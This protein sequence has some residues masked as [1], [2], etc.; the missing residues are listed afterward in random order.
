MRRLFGLGTKQRTFEFKCESCNEIHRG[1]PSFAIPQPTYVHDVPPDER[2][3]RLE[4]SEDLCVIQPRNDSEQ[5]TIF[6]I[7]VLLEI[8]IHGAEE[9]FSWG[10]WV[11]QSE[12]S[13]ARY[14]E[15]FDQDQSGD[16]SFGWLPMTIGHYR[17]TEPGQDIEHLACDVYWG[18]QGQRPRIQLRECDHPLAVDQ[19]EG[20]SW[21]TAVAI[22]RKVMHPPT[23]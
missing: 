14:V 3:D 8:P 23:D 20:I 2:D 17:R 15:T 10:V 11:T 16:G 5:G 21:E 7:R 13:F 9:P 18:P 4:L 22:A 6:C 19:H 1:S 12:A